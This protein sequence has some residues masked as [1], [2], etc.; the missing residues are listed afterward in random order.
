MLA[1]LELWMLF[2]VTGEALS[3]SDIC[4]PGPRVCRHE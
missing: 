1:Q 4:F 3:V 2:Q